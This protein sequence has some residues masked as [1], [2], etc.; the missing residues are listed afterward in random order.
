MIDMG[1][2]LDSYCS[3]ITRMAM[4][5][6][7]KGKIKG[8]YSVVRVAQEKALDAIRPGR[9]I[10]EVDNAGRQYITDKGYGKFFGHS[11]GHGVG[12][13]VHEEPSISR[14]SKEILRP[15]MVFT[16]EPAIYIP[17]LGG[18]RIEDMVLVTENGYEI[19]TR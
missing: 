18:V 10:S 6:N 12:L 16:V 4:I 17:K 5:G 3:D 15:G 13:E 9:P 8:I 2:S 14:R 11:I 7:V 1:C 19:L